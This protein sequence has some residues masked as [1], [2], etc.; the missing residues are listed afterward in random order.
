MEFLKTEWSIGPRGE[1]FSKK[2]ISG[3]RLV[4]TENY[5]VRDFYK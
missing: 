5:D 3:G 2:I 4:G 1:K